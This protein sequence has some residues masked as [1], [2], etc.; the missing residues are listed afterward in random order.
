MFYSILNLFH[1]PIGQTA[2]FSN[3]SELLI[4]VRFWKQAKDA[5]RLEPKSEWSGLEVTMRF[6]S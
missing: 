6:Q 4:N 1:L 3:E 2:K 5:D